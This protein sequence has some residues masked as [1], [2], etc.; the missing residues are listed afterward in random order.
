MRVV[1][2]VNVNIKQ[3]KNYMFSNRGL[4][5]RDQQTAR[6]AATKQCQIKIR[7]RLTTSP[8]I[9]LALYWAPTEKL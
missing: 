2:D 7:V 9:Y 3:N 5:L 1:I 8:A 6:H 4:M